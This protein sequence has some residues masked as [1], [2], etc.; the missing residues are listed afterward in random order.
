MSQKN[1]MFYQIIKITIVMLLM[2]LI[3]S[4]VGCSTESKIDKLIQDL[5]N[6]DAQVQN[7]AAEELA[8]IGEP[9]VEALIAV[10][11]DK[12]E[13]VRMYAERALN[14]IG[15][16]AVEGL[17]EALKDENVNVRLISSRILS[18]IED[19]RIIEPLINALRDE[20]PNVCMYAERGLK[21]IG[22][23]AIESL[24]LALTDG[25]VNLRISVS[26]I[27]SEVEDTRIIEPMVNALR[28]EES[29]VCMY[30]E[31][32]LKKMGDFSIETLITALKDEN[33]NVRIASS[34]IL[35]EVE[36]TRIIEPLIIAMKDKNERVRMYAQR[37]LFNM[38]ELAID[39][40]IVALTDEN[41]NICLGAVQILSVIEDPRVI[42]PLTAAL[43]NEDP[44]VR[45]Y[46]ERGLKN[47][48]VT[49][50]KP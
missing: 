30:A 9:A 49:I 44:S 25:N 34:R 7:K 8:K 12:E 50:V 15:E 4:F 46:A 16:P 28:D 35:S 2:I 14:K 6:K 13:S 23:P 27:L 45:M 5:K 24:I 21:N 41:V 39:P 32:G 48:G 17:I 42:E 47:M 31:R 22:E 33:E 36:D 38:G 1:R 37:G 11:K 26:R 19:E 43:K 29:N 40:L 3:L 10:L 18:E 20:D